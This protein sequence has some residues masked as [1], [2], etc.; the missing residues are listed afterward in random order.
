MERPRLRNATPEETDRL[1]EFCTLTDLISSMRNIEG[2]LA[3]G[4]PPLRIELPFPE[5]LDWGEAAPGL[6]CPVEFAREAARLYYSIELREFTLP[7]ANPLLYRSYSAI[8]DKLAL[9]LAEEISI[10]E[11]VTRWL[12]AC[13]P[14]LQRGEIARQLAMSERTLTRRLQA[15]GSSYKEL[16]AGVQCERA[17]NL[18]RNEGLSVSEVAERLG[19]AEPAAF[20]R[21]FRAWTGDSP[22]RWR[23]SQTR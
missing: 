2:M 3:R 23:R 14:P 9:M 7:G 13:S 5:P 6:P 11:R 18:L 22:L 10:T 21:A 19:Y 16:L 4:Y 12:W 8:A 20:T 15:E 17:E 1:V